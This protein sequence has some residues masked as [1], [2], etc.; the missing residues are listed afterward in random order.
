MDTKDKN[1]EHASPGLAAS[2]SATMPVEGAGVAQ[3]AEGSAIPADGKQ[4]KKSGTP[5]Q[6][7]LR[8]LRR[9]VRAMVSIGFLLFFIILPIVGP[10]I[11]RNIGPEM[12]TSM[13]DHV[14]SQVYRDPFHQELDNQDQGPSAYYWLGTDSIGRDLF[15]RLMQG[16][17]ISLVVAI[18]VEIVTVF[19]GIFFG[20]MAGYFGGWID[21]IL[22]RF[23]DIMFAFPGLLFAILLTGIFGSSADTTFSS[24]PLIGQNG[25]ARLVLVSIALALVQW[26]FIARLVR[27]QALQLREQQFVE[28]ARSTGTTNFQIIKRH[29][30]PNLIAIIIVQVSLDLGGIIIGEA[31][32]SFLGLGVQ[33]PGSSIGLMIS[34]AQNLVDTHPWEVLLPSIVL[35]IIV[36][37]FS[38]LGDGLRDAFDPRSKD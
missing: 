11:Y 29:I 30:I 15:S 28:A 6:E 10:P 23:T 14:T 2:D 20:V 31:G 33:P 26:P 24:I 3:P 21:Q 36:L 18:V 25:N 35:T 12:V 4:P 8:R 13:G 16:M 17:L 9:D 7:S 27:G 1:S 32:L 37:A 5:F 38:F 19:L 34:D 22:A